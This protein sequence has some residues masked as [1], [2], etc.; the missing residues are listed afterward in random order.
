VSCASQERQRPRPIKL[1][2]CPDISKQ[3]V[4]RDRLFTAIRGSATIRGNQMSFDADI[5]ARSPS[6]LRVEVAG[7]LGIKLG[8]LVMNDDWVKFVVPREKLV[9]QIPKSEIDKKTLRAERFLSAIV[10]PLPPDLMIAAVTTQSPLAVGAKML[11]CRYLPK[12]NVYELRLADAGSRGGSILSLDPTTLAPLEWRRY[13]S[14]L[15]DLSS[16]QV[17]RY[18]YRVVFKDLQGQAMSTIPAKSSL[19]SLPSKEPIS[20]LKWVRVEVWTDPIDSAFEFKHS[21]S[22]TIKD[23]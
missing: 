2:D 3:L 8:L 13:E 22:F 18:S 7:P 11:A 12:E 6:E 20:E 1:L 9:M 10:V 23:Y 15:P 21:A 16:D 19:W 4:Q 17:E 14:F 5:A